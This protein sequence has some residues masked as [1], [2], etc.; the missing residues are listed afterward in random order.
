MTGTSGT[1]PCNRESDLT[2]LRQSQVEIKQTAEK[3]R[4]E[5]K[6]DVHMIRMDTDS[7]KN[8]FMELKADIREV[9]VSLK[10]VAS[11]LE[12]QNANYSG[13]ER[14]SRDELEKVIGRLSQVEGRIREL[15]LADAKSSWV[16]KVIWAAL[17]GIGAFVM[18]FI[19][20]KVQG[21]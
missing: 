14:R 16:D 12:T 19:L 2:A 13:V 3:M 10:S 20:W 15:E 1:P 11:V 8:G 7:L 17:S 5:L 21:V 4:D 18:A 6:A 9:V